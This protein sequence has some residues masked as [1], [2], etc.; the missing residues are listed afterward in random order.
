M[1]NGEE[2]HA[3]DGDCIAALVRVLEWIAWQDGA[4]RVRSPDG[5]ILAPSK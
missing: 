1:A 4:D 5:E 3:T 2:G